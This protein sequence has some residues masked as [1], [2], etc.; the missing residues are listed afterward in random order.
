MA[1]NWLVWK[2][3]LPSF[4]P[5][6]FQVDLGYAPFH[7]EPKSSKNKSNETNVNYLSVVF[8]I[9]PECD[10]LDHICFSHKPLDSTTR[11]EIDAAT[12][13]PLF[14]QKMTTFFENFPVF[15]LW[16]VSPPPP[17]C[18]PFHMLISLRHPLTLH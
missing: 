5:Y 16:V 8:K 11:L 4:S 3:A 6:I 12:K 17:L 18:L 2:H 15:Y 9:V 13:S 14:K 10:L 1:P 7:P